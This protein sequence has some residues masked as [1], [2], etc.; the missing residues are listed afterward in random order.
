MVR[1]KKHLDR[2]DRT[3]VNWDFARVLFGPN[4]Q[5]EYQRY[6][7]KEERETKSSSPQV[8]NVRVNKRFASELMGEDIE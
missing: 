4:I 3:R 6:E 2:P 1:R 8:T 7:E 5:E